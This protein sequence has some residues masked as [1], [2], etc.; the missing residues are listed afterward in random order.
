M[1]V[2]QETLR[3][4][5]AC[6]HWFVHPSLSFSSSTEQ[7]L[8]IR[9]LRLASHVHIIDNGFPRLSVQGNEIAWEASEDAISVI[10]YDALTRPP[11][12]MGFDTNYT[13]FA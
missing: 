13:N 9:R 5:I 3:V 12:P 4:D 1:R 2:Y 7:E 11:T 6:P 10:V 8:R